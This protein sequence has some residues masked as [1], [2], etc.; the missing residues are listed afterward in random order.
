M[1]GGSLQV[2]RLLPPLKLVAMILL[3]LASNTK[4]QSINQSS[5]LYC[6][7]LKIC[8]FFNYAIWSENV[9][10]FVVLFVCKRYRFCLFLRFWYLILELF[11]QFFIFVFVFK[12]IIIFNW[13]SRLTVNDNILY[14]Q[15][16]MSDV[17]LQ[18]TSKMFHFI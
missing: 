12:S 5:R 6:N 1:V 3:K 15:W 4:N 13:N 11:R 2:P 8:R 10:D 17:W 7:Y 9:W 14:E 18:I 16:F